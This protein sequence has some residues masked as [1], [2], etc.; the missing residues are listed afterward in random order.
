[1]Q[2]LCCISSHGGSAFV[3]R[4]MARASIFGNTQGRATL[5]VSESCNR[6]MIAKPESFASK[7]RPFK[8]EVFFCSFAHHYVSV[9]G[10]RL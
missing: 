7:E 10:T 3:S 4:N 2:D 8:A 6:C 1:M 9:D 5:A